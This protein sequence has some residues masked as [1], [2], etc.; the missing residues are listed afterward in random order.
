MEYTE[1]FTWTIVM[2]AVIGRIISTK[3]GKTAASNFLRSQ[4]RIAATSIL[5]LIAAEHFCVRISSIQSVGQAGSKSS[6]NFP[7]KSAGRYR[8]GVHFHGLSRKK[9]QNGRF[10]RCNSLCRLACL[11]RLRGSWEILPATCGGGISLNARRRFRIRIGLRGRRWM[12]LIFIFRGVL[13]GFG[14]RGEGVEWSDGGPACWSG[15]KIWLL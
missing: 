3:C 15:E 1:F 4:S 5:S 6:R 13:A 2:F 11:S 9:L 10:G 14:L 8:S 12:S 7:G